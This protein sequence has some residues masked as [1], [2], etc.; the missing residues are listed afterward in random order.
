MCRY[1]CIRAYVHPDSVLAIAD[2]DAF[3]VCPARC[4][5]CFMLVYVC[6]LCVVCVVRSV[7]VCVS[8]HVVL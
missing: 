2:A 5:L 6:V 3:H 1:M 8:S 7:C 4:G